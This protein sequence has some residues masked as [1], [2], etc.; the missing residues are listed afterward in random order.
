VFVYVDECHLVWGDVCGYVWGPSDQRL[1]VPITNTRE[2]QTY[3]GALNPFTHETI[4]LPLA[5]GNS[6][7]TLLFLTYLREYFAEKRLIICWDNA[8][9]HRS[10][11]VHDYLEVVNRGHAADMWP[12]TCVALAPHAPDQNPIE[13]LWLQAKTHLRRA[14]SGCTATFTGIIALF[15]AAIDKI[16]LDTRKM[17]IHFPTSDLK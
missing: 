16:E 11:A 14:W 1:T 8:S 17:Q 4:V 12:I 3:F 5:K 15:E 13:D 10:C 7:Q 6:D 2:R 9:Y